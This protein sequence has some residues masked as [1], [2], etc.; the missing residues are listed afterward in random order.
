MNEKKCEE[1]RRKLDLL[2]DDEKKF[3]LWALLS[4][5]QDECNQYIR[6]HEG[7]AS[8]EMAE[9]VRDKA[10]YVQTIIAYDLW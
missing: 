10:A 5:F 3:I 1:L 7:V 2:P 6:E 8:A 9:L 4:D